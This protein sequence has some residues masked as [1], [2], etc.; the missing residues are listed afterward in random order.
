MVAPFSVNSDSENIHPAVTAA[1]PP[2]HKNRA[3]TAAVP[4]THKNRA[5]TAAVP[6]T[7]TDASHQ[8]TI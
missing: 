8:N 4:P 3:V 5:V 2:T 1:V 7:H 6:P